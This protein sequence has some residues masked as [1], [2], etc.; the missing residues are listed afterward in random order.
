MCPAN[1]LATDLKE[2][3]VLCD[4]LNKCQLCLSLPGS[5]KH[6]LKWRTGVYILQVCFLLFLHWSLIVTQKSHYRVRS[7]FLSICEI[8]CPSSPCPS[9]KAGQNEKPSLRGFSQQDTV[10]DSLLCSISYPLGCIQSSMQ[11]SAAL[12]IVSPSAE[13]KTARRTFL[14]PSC[15]SSAAACWPFKS[16]QGEGLI[17]RPL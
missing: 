1:R 17:T 2:H 15:V 6:S 4:L 11:T 3:E 7:V 12:G 16:C 5:V 10:F 9:F 14:L 13:A 8:A